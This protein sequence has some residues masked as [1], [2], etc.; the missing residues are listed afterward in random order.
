MGLG[1]TGFAIVDTLTELGVRVCAVAQRAQPDVVNIAAVVG[2]TVV[3]DDAVAPRVEAARRAEADFVVVSPGIDSEDPVVAALS[4]GGVPV[5]SDVDFAWRVRDKE[6]EPAQW[7]VVTG[8]TTSSAIADLATRIMVADG[9]RARHVGFGASPVLDALRDPEPYDT[10]II[11]A[12]DAS[13]Q[14]WQRH[15]E[16]LRRPVVTVSI[17]APQGQHT[18]ARFDGTTMACVYRR[19]TGS[20]EALVEDA[21]VIDGARAVGVG[22]DAPGMSDLGLVEGIV[23]DRA[24]LESRAH[25]ALEISTVEE[26]EEAGWRVPEDLATILAATAIARSQDISPALIAG[27]LS[28]P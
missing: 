20:T 11:S 8:T 1:D 15:P 10:L 25:Q 7:I 17:E 18:G 24:F 5:W 13:A 21:E 28:L 16:A 4:A 23:C 19:G 14:W 3:V 9:R 27:V 6:P 2:A 12:S 22:L 26:L